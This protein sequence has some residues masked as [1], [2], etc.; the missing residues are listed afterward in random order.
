MYYIIE[1]YDIFRGDKCII[2]QVP[3]DSID[4]QFIKAEGLTVKP[5][6]V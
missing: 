2:R 4:W 1:H 6:K 3:C 5:S